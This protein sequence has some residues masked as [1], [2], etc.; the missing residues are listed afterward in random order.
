M[1]QPLR[2][3]RKLAGA[4]WRAPSDPQ[5]F[6]DLEIDATRLLEH[7]E[8]VR[9]ASGV[10]V[11]V[12]HAVVRAIA[13]ALEAVPELNV[14]IARGRAHPRESIDVLVI[15]AAAGDELTGV[16]VSGADRKSLVEVATDIE[17]RVASIRADTDLEF[18]RTKQMLALLPKPV[19]RPALRLSAWLTSDLN[20]HLPRLGLPQQAFGGAMV[21]SI[22]MAGISH[23]YSPLAAYYRVPFLVLV[24]SVTDKAVVEDG[25]VVVRPVL[26]LT[27]TF[28]HRYTDGLR[29]AALARAARE[30]LMDP[31][32]FEPPPA[33]TGVRT[34]APADGR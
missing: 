26:G 2:G 13:R 17:S 23:A 9:R 15:V 27:A 5:F 14:R 20:L 1:S 29:A 22:G 16:K 32:T 3:W 24:G 21:S 25:Q 33:E 4:S 12:T 11:T 30:Y 31:A 8:R 10:H 28:D 34:A 18:G 6:G 19:L 7:L